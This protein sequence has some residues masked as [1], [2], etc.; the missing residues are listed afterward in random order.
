MNVKNSFAK[1]QP[2]ES[3]NNLENKLLQIWERVLQVKQIST[4]DNFFNLGGDS[5]KAF[6][7]LSELGGSLSLA[8]VYHNPTI[9]DLACYIRNKPEMAE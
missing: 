4:K 1:D 7:L 9:Q 8:E 5:F 3:L 6:N 2:K